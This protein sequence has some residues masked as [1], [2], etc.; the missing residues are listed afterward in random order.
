M[1]LKRADV[2]KLV[3]LCYTSIFNLERA[4]KFPARR[5]ISAGRVGWLRSEVEAWVES[6]VAV[7]APE[8]I[9]A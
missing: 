9:A 3:G 7:P 2:V 5:R 4:G 1:V 8:S 6:R